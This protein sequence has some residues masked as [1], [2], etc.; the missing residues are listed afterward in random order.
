MFPPD[1]FA[2]LQARYALGKI[3]QSHRLEGGE[4]KT[5]LRIDC[6]RGAF[7]VSVSH[8]SA[9]REG[10]A[11]EHAF[12]RYLNA[13]LPQI[14]A[15]LVAQDESTYFFADGRIVT[16]FPFIPGVIADRDQMRLP[17]ARFL[18]QY[19]Q[20]ALDY[21]NRAARPD[22]PAWWCLDWDANYAWHWPTVW[23][24]LEST[25]ATATGAAQRF[26]QGGGAWAKAIQARRDQI[27]A[28]RAHFQ[29]WL[30]QLAHSARPLRIAPI[31][32]DYHRK[33]LLCNGGQITA[34]LDWDGCHPDWLV[35]DL[36]LAIWEFCKD[37]TKTTMDHAQV[38]AFIGA[39]QMANG[40]VP[41]RDFDLI[42]PLIRCRR[43]IEVLFSLQGIV[44][45]DTWDEDFAEYA[46]G[47]LVALEKLNSASLA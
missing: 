26:W 23:T 42:I 5:L 35:F 27:A 37:R 30:P 34:L 17:A 6:D 45:G 22:I 19:H 20:A 14:A 21:P 29:V 9:V 8:P 33:N 12:L 11:Y 28:E 4:W 15:P 13:R 46:M 10:V 2:T 3:Y 16:L 43:I 1:F 38:Q 31:H 40:P 32:D 25:S 36:S 44:N 7:V 18:A 39:Y 47:N 41:A 24:L